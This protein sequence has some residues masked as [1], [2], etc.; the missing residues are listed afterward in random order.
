MAVG[1]IVIHDAG[2][3]GPVGNNKADII[4]YFQYVLENAEV[5]YEYVPSANQTI[6][7]AN[8]SVSV[9]SYSLPTANAHINMLLNNTVIGTINFQAGHANGTFSFTDFTMQYGDLFQLINQTVADATLGNIRLT[10]A[11]VR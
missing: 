9:P 6:M 2:P 10:L 4:L 11:G 5:L 1:T 3:Q 8:S 7:N